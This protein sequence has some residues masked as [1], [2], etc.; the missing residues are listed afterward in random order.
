MD[1]KRIARELKRIAKQL[2]ADNDSLD[3][4]VLDYVEA[5]DCVYDRDVKDM[6]NEFGV[7]TLDIRAALKRLVKEGDIFRVGNGW[8]V[9]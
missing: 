9:R 8:S 7:D 3:F 6:A 5:G 4:K 2:E 1:A